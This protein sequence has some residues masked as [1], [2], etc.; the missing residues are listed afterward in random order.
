[1]IHAERA[2]AL[3]PLD[4]GRYMFQAVAGF[5]HLFAG[6][7]DR[8]LDF[9]RKSL[10]LYDW[11]STYWVLIPAYVQLGRIAE[12]QAGLAKLVSLSPGLTVSGI[13]ERVPIRNPASLEMIMEGL[14]KAG[15]PA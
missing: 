8:A 9:A 6:R 3:S 15:L 4:P 11:D 7:P 2:M 10:A 12:A 1:M 5:A 14:E 13:R